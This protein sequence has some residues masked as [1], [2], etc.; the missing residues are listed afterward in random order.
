MSDARDD[1]DF[2]SAQEAGENASYTNQDVAREDRLAEES[3]ATGRISQEEVSGLK[4]SIGG[5]EILDDSEGYTRNAGQK[6]Y[7]QADEE[8]DAAVEADA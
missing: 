8:L 2:V 1:Q 4:D 7:A 3:E 5:G 6:N